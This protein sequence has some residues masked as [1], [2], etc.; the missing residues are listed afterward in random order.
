MLLRYANKSVRKVERRAAE[1]MIPQKQILCGKSEFHLEQE[2][3]SCRDADEDH[4]KSVGSPEPNGE[5]FRVAGVPATPC[6]RSST[7]ASESRRG[8]RI[9]SARSSSLAGPSGRHGADRR[10]IHSR[11]IL[12]KR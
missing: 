10:C 12:T 9:R 7:K 4:Y 5:R 3:K 2:G 8:I 1:P 11:W 6:C